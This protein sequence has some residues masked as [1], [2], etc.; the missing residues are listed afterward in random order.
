MFTGLVDGMGTVI[1][2][3][4]RGAD[5][6]LS[7][8]VPP[9]YLDDAHE[10]D[11]IAV[12]GVCLTLLAGGEGELHVDASVETLACTTLGQRRPGDAVNLERALR[13]GDRLG[14]H[15]VSGHVD[16]CATLREQ[17]PDGRAQR[18][19]FDAPAGLARY[20][21]P[22]GSVCLDGV[23]LTVNAVT[24]ARFEVCI[25]PHTLEVT[26]LGALQPGASVNLEVDLLARYL[27][28]L[29]DARDTTG[30][31]ANGERS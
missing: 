3:E 23:S 30:D 31:G 24:G 10:G 27:A 22:K 16:G 26:T 15:L 5:E 20:I 1:A 11:S 4:P 29:W 19:E 8:S 6:R 25:I 2:R 21:A 17:R 14:G 13:V 7:I 12:A 9:G 28:R 18:L